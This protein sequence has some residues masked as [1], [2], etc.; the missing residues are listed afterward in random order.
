[1]YCGFEN[2]QQQNCSESVCTCAFVFVFVF[3]CVCVC[4]QCT[5]AVLHRCKRCIKL[6][7]F[8]ISFAPT[9]CNW[10]GRTHRC[11][12]YRLNT[13]CMQR[14]CWCLSVDWTVFV[15]RS[16]RVFSWLE[17]LLM[18]TFVCARI[19]NGKSVIVSCNRQRHTDNK[20][21]YVSICAIAFSPYVCRT[22]KHCYF[23]L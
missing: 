18:P 15:S 22:N 9:Q 12:N 11:C 3:V 14:M 8:R 23:I 10:R 7:I 4:I 2:C 1:M 17:P 13:I 5:H 21:M 16:Q 19:W 20:Q 6:T